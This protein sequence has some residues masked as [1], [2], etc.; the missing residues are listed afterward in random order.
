V[1]FSKEATLLKTYRR[2]LITLTSEYGNYFSPTVVEE[3]TTN[4]VITMSW[5]EGETLLPWLKTNPSSEQRQGLAHLV[6]NLYCHEFFDWGLVQTDPN[7]SNFLIRSPDQKDADHVGL[8]IL[9]F[10]S[11]R[12]YERAMIHEYVDLLKAV[13]GGSP[14]VILQ[15][16]FQ[17]GL[18]DPRES[19]ETKQLFVDMMNLAIE[20]FNEEIFDFT[21]TDYSRRSQTVIKEFVRSLKY[22]PPPHRI[23]FLH[24][25]LGGIF[26]LLK[27]LE[28]KLN[29]KPYWELMVN[30]KGDLL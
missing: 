6:L 7:F 13:E 11:T 27:R 3:L 21:S 20:P 16:A 28:V 24:R 23:L 14:R 8:V 19:G 4:K 30:K 22:S 18:L 17:F 1:D 26:S 10:G 2:Q 29:I 12:H 9:D 25:K 5:E 15:N